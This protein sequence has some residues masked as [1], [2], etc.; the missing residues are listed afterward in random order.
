VPVSSL[1]TA[2]CR[3]SGCDEGDDLAGTSNARPHTARK[4][5]EFAL[6]WQGLERAGVQLVDANGRV[7]LRAG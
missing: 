4:V 6:V 7:R 3:G 5:E 2:I 1:L